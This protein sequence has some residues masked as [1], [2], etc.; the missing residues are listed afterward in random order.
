MEVLLCPHTA[1]TPNALPWTAGAT[2]GVRSA[3]ELAAEVGRRHDLFD[4]TTVVDAARDMRPPRGEQD[5]IQGNYVQMHEDPTCNFRDKA[6]ITAVARGDPTGA[7][8]LVALHGHDVNERDNT[9]WTPAIHLCNRDVRSSSKADQDDLICE[10][11]TLQC[12]GADMRAISTQ[13]QHCLLN[14]ARNGLTDVVKYLHEQCGC[15]T[16]QTT[17]FGD[18][19]LMGAA[20]WG[21][22][23]TVKYL[24]NVGVDMHATNGSDAYALLQ[25]AENVHLDVIKTFLAAGHDR[26]KFDPPSPSADAAVAHKAGSGGHVRTGVLGILA[27]KRSIKGVRL[28]LDAGANTSST[29][30]LESPL[31]VAINDSDQ[32]CQLALIDAGADLG[33][34]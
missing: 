7:L 5:I 12:A 8:A 18:T 28:M 15:S 33:V 30:H 31:V 4:M 1:Q 17:V 24:L 14:A 13:G 3:D 25:A 34:A 21:H 11:M 20:S 22:N 6:V 9:A 16:E 10:L 23:S 19:P 29:K 26:D 2:L 32:Q 27:N